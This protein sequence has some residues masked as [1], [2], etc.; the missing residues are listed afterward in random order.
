MK[1]TTRTTLALAALALAGLASAGCFSRATMTK[2]HGRAYRQ[3]FQRQA[4]TPVSAVSTK[5]PKGLDALESTIVV[6]TY[7]KGL[8]PGGGG[9]QD[10]MIVLSPGAGSPGHSH[11]APAPSK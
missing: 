1:K 9:S 7:R 8:A 4:V 3:A 6:E 2:S 11:G 5:A 10:Q